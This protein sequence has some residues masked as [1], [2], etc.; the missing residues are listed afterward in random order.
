M[1]EA[2]AMQQERLAQIGEK[3]K[4]KAELE[5]LQ[6]QRQKE[7]E[8][9]EAPEKEA[10]DY[11]RQLEEEER[12][13]KVRYLCIYLKDLKNNGEHLR[14]YFSVLDPDLC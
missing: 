12:K 5:T 9:A 3:E 7:K 10:L 13:K 11:Y 8:E 14:I 4:R 6:L 1:K 2:Q